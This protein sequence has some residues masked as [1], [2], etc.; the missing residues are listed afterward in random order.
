STKPTGTKA[1]MKKR[2]ASIAT[3][4]LFLLS[5]EWR[6]P[7]RLPNIRVSTVVG[8]SPVDPKQRRWKGVMMRSGPSL[9][10]LAG[11]A[12][13]ATLS[14]RAVAVEQP[15]P[16]TII[17]NIQDREE[18][19]VALFQMRVVSTSG[20]RVLEKTIQAALAKMRSLSPYE[21]ISDFNDAIK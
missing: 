1:R 10:L 5:S 3:T 19:R 2:L 11:I 20:D 16:P 18:M 4:A 8:I 17:P 15:R 9:K 21:A 14:G 12:V 6:L 13:T 7:S